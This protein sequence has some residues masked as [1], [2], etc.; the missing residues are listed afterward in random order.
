LIVKLRYIRL[1]VRFVPRER[2]GNEASDREESSVRFRSKDCRGFTLVELMIVVAIIGILAAIALP[3]F[4][5]FKMKAKTA[6]AKANLSAIRSMEIAYFTEYDLYITGQDWT[7]THGADRSARL[8]WNPNTRFS[9]LG[10]AP[11]GDVFFEYRLE[12][13]GVLESTSYTVSARSDLDND[14][15]WSVYTLGSGSLVLEH[16]GGLY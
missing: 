4:M 11:D 8:A 10:Y 5:R 9:W 1:R 6:E 2:E 14:G 13:V 12:P 7:P 3:N 16:S 15:S